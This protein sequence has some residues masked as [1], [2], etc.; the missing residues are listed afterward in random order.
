[1]FGT[2]DSSSL[3]ISLDAKTGAFAPGFGAAA[4][5]ISGRGSE[6]NFRSFASRCPRRRRFTGTWRSPGNIRRRPRAWGRTATSERGIC[7]PASSCGRSTPFHRPGEPNHDAWNNDQWV[8]RAG[9]NAWGF[10]TVDEARGIA[11]VPTGTPA[12]D[13]YGGDR[14]GSNLYGSSL[15]AL[16]A[17]TGKL[18][19]YFQTTH[20]DNWDYDLTSPPALIDVR[21]NG[22]TIPAVAMYTKQG[23]V[24]IFIGLTG[25]PIYG[26]EERP[27]VS[28]NPLPGDEYSPTQP[29]PVKPPPI[30]RMTFSP[31]EVAKV[32]P[33]HEK[34]CKDLL[35]LEGG[36]M[37]GGPYAQYGPKL[38]VIFP[39]LDGRRQL[40]RCRVRSGV[41]G[42]FFTPTQDIGMLNKMVKSTRARTCMSA[43]ALTI[44]RR[45][46]ARISGM[47]AR[48]GR[49]SSRHGASS[50][51]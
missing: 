14:L 15:L 3:L 28:D 38:R 40:E 48:A 50:S 23:L 36:V 30:A 29:F 20:H 49:A 25:E 2:G 27:V 19:W 35:E 10:I 45:C 37:T 11:F 6:R 42:Y 41:S 33:E 46:S 4:K 24:F 9:A 7:E 47:A 31:S 51:Q 8:D 13:F 12:T 34:Y 16:D 26:V 43:A 17:M 1:M 44:H 22:K 5:S 32:T 18:K 21:R 39:G